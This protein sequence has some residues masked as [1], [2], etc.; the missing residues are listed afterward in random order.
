MTY[1]QKQTFG[2]LLKKNRE[3]LNFTQ[4]ECAEYCE[5]SINAYQFWERGN[6]EPSKENFDKICNLLEINKEQFA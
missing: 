4:R 6:S 1:K 5:V 3:K 2:E